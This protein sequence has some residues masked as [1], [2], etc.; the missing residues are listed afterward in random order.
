MRDGE[1]E[2]G[3]SERD[4]GIFA[5]VHKIS[6]PAKGLELQLD[7]PKIFGPYRTEDIAIEDVKL[8]IDSGAI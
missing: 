1:Y 5:I 7:A 4:D 8:A 6:I 2:I 3:V